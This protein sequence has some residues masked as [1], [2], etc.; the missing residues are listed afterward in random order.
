MLIN[1][2]VGLLSGFLTTTVTYPWDI[3]HTRL[4][5]S[6]SL[7]GEKPAFRGAFHCYRLIFREE[8]FF[9]VWKGYCVT[10]AALVPN[11]AITFALYDVF[12]GIIINAKKTKS[13][14]SAFVQLLSNGG[15][16]SLA[17]IIANLVTY[18][19]DTVKRRIQVQ[20]EGRTEKLY[21]GALDC[22]KK[23]PAKE[24]VGALYAGIVPHLLKIAP[25]AA[26]QFAAY[27]FL[28]ERFAEGKPIY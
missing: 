8:G 20:N 12:R 5:A 6:P 23:L 21:K 28:R 3:I 10:L 26:V 16:G 27:D 15:A 18:P 22:L 25:A 24:G 4:A 1:L 17:G 14:D 19:L 7:K 11:V 9:K 13:D 2:Q